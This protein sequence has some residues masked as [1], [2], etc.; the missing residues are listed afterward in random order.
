MMEERDKNVN[1]L[2][3]LNW[4][5]YEIQRK[6]TEEWSDK[7]KGSKKLPIF[8]NILMAKFDNFSS[9]LENIR[10]IIPILDVLNFVHIRNA[11]CQSFE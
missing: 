7:E 2:T 3:D 1:Q 10:I 6:N 8:D 11:K 9:W 4:H 5:A